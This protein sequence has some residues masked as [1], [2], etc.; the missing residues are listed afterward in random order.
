M[1]AVCPEKVTKDN[2]GYRDYAQLMESFTSY[3]AATT[4][5]PSTNTFPVSLHKLLNEVERL[6]MESIIGW[7]PNGRCILVHDPDAFEKYILPM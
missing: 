6:G 2:N 1:E 7:R 3:D 5:G 4:G